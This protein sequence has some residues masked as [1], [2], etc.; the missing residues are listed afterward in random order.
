MTFPALLSLPLPRFS[1]PAAAHGGAGAGAASAALPTLADLVARQSEQATQL[2]RLEAQQAAVNAALLPVLQKGL[3]T[4]LDLHDHPICCGFF[5]TD[6]GVALT[7]RHDHVRFVRP[8]GKIHAVMLKQVPDEV[9]SSAAGG[10]EALAPD[11]AKLVF[12]IHSFSEDLDFTCMTL[13]SPLP[14]GAFQPLSLP[15]AGV[16]TSSLI[17]TQATLLHGSIAYNRLFRMDPSPSLVPCHIFTA[18]RERVL[19]SSSTFGG[20]SG[21]ALIMRGDVLIGMHVEGLNDVAE[22]VEVLSPAA[23]ADGRSEPSRLRLSEASPFT[24]AAA[25][26]LDLAAIRAAVNAAHAHVT[27]A[28]AAA[29]GV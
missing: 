8:G 20:D 25:L 22:D 18:H 26:R 6:A 29:G 1:T 14:A 9:S 11:E 17:G 24:A 5:V 23:A 13:S 19:F 12:D 7:V 15:A 27:G 16:P 3:F 4:V 10:S 21:G 2:A 28:G